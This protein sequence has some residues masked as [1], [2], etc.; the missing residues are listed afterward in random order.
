M[1]EYR[2]PPMS[3]KPF[4]LFLSAHDAV[5]GLMA[6]ALLRNRAGDRFEVLSAGVFPKEA[7][8]LTRRVLE[9]I[10]I[11]V[12][13]LASRNVRDYLARIPVQIAVILGGEEA[14]G[15][16]LYPFAPTLLRWHV[17]DPSA[18]D[19]PDAERVERFRRTRDLLRDRIEA[20]V[21]GA[22]SASPDPVFSGSA[23][24]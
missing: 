8:P 2:H 15:P 23:A 14:L 6:E 18:G 12:R 20:W 21:T 9:E 16:K 7:H 13:G 24:R 11:D 22:A 17:E 3:S 1:F 5:R 19:F 4:V 10:G